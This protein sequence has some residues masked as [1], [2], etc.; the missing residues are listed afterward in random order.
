MILAALYELA[1]RERWVDDADFE[2]KRVDFRLHVGDDGRFLGLVPTAQDDRAA[3][4]PVPR[5]PKRAGIG[6]IPGFLFDNAKYV[7]GLGGSRNQECVGAFR[8]LVDALARE[9]HDAGA[10]AVARFYERREEQLHDIVAA[11][12]NGAFTGSEWIAF[13]YQDD[14][15][16]VHERPAVR[17]YWSA[18][19]RAMETEG[20]GP[21]R[22]LV[23]GEL[24]VPVRLH[25][26][27]KRVPPGKMTQGAPLVSF[28]PPQGAFDSRGQSQGNNAPISRAAAE[29]YVT[30]LNA[31][32]QGTPERRFKYG[33]PLGDDGVMVFWTR[34]EH[35]IVDDF[36]N[37]MDPSVTSGPRVA[38][39]FID[40]TAPAPDARAAV[41]LAESPL[42]GLLPGDLDETEFYALTLSECSARIAVRDWLTTTVG[43]IKKHLRAYFDALT[44][45]GQGERPLSIRALLASVE[46]PSGRGLSPDLGVRLLC[47]ALR[48]DPFPRELLGAALRRLRLPPHKIDERRQLHARCALVKATLMRPSFGARQEVPVSL[49]EDSIQ[50]PYLLGR[51]FAVLERL[52]G[53]AQGDI[54]ATIR[55][56]YFGAASSTPA[57]VFPRL[58]RLSMHHAAKADAG[59]WYEQ[60]K[61]R[62]IAAL[63]AEPF[64]S[65]LPIQDQGLFAI[66]YYHQRQKLFEKRVDAPPPGA[67]PPALPAPAPPSENDHE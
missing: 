59:P 65:T 52:Q 14:M 10:R 57:V 9:T 33:V 46:T 45:T 29:G 23:T 53:A 49:D 51:L 25:N 22:C 63:P 41:K 34:R 20:G 54:N 39:D 1:R 19:R 43:A 6:A 60:Q 5:L 66:G 17:A 56:R 44:L 61:T 11:H 4:I 30:A 31:L 37:L 27:I 28:N 67:P 12:P 16:A 15:E 24:A 36:L 2:N 40:L 35:P 26:N 42:K 13:V 3:V 62:I 55:D 32:L 38:D 8:A 58:L 64:P 7:L 18:R 21:M 47:A 50:V 48:G